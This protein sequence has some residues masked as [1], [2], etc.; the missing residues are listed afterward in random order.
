MSKSF[1]SNWIIYTSLSHAQKSGL[2][3]GQ[4]KLAAL[5]EAQLRKLTNPKTSFGRQ[6]KLLKTIRTKPASTT[7]LCRAAGVSRR[8]LFR[9]LAALRAAGVDI[10]SDGSDFSLKDKKLSAVLGKFV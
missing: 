8:T 2:F 9:D 5:A 7:M 10:V 3:K 4:K 6:L 1:A